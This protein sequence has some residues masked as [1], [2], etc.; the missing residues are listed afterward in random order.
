MKSLTEQLPPE[1]AQQIDLAW[2]KNEADYW[3]A[4]DRLLGQYQGQ[5]VGFADGSVIAACVSWIS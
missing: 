5:W 4:R 1:V 2:R 3:A